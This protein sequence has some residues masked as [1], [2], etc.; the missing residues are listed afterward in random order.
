MAA[1]SRRLLTAGAVAAAVLTACTSVEPSPAPPT[2][3]P[4]RSISETP[5]PTPNLTRADADGCPVTQPTTAPPEMRE[6]LFGSGSAH[7]NDDLWVGGLG[8]DG[9]MAID[10]RS[11]DTD[12]SIGTKLGWWRN[13]PGSV[14]ISGR[15]LD[16]P[17]PPASGEGSDGYGN[18]GFQASG[19][20]FPTEGCWEITGSIGES[21]LTFVT[22]VF[23][24]ANS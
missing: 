19:V 3:T 16:S 1:S 11:V 2:A 20:H 10:E 4:V 24:Q 12:G 21:E 8:E 22:F 9:I 15:R 13:V 17:A 23:V 14:L 7:G 18:L 5:S 6:R